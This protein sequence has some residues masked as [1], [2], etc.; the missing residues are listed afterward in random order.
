MGRRPYQ[1][2]NAWMHYGTEQWWADVQQMPALAA[3]LVSQRAS[4]GGL[5]NPSEV[6]SAGLAAGIAVLQ[7]GLNSAA[8][9]ADDLQNIFDNCKVFYALFSKEF[10]INLLHHQGYNRSR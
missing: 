5:R 4:K 1:D 8:L 2:W 9:D 3:E 10:V 7:H 6:T